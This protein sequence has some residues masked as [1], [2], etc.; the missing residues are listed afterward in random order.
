M[1]TQMRNMVV[2]SQEKVIAWC[3]DAAAR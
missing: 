2:S 1:P 3:S